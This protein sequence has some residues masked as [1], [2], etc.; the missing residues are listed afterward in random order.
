MDRKAWRAQVVEEPLE[1]GLPIIDAHHHI[2]SSTPAEPWEP[3]DAEA[4]IADKA[5][6]GH[7]VIA[8]VYVDSHA[9]YRTDGPAELRVVGESEFADS[10]AEHGLGLGGRAAG[11]CAGIVAHADLPLGTSVGRSEGHTS[12]F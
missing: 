12:E 6:A 10:V 2:W 8:T 3:Y 11:I 5:E 1:P 9:N 7:N 4:V